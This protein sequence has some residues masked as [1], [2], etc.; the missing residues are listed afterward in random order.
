[1]L[2]CVITIK[3][4]GVSKS[5]C[6][7]NDKTGP[8]HSMIKDLTVYY[9]AVYRHCRT[10]RKCDPNE[11]LKRFLENRDKPTSNRTGTNTTSL[12]VNLVEK[13]IKNVPGTDAGWLAKYVARCDNTASIEKHRRLLTHDQLVKAARGTRYNGWVNFADEFTDNEFLQSAM[14]CI[15]ALSENLTWASHDFVI[16]QVESIANKPQVSPG[17]RHVFKNLVGLMVNGGKPD[18]TELR[19]M[20][21]I[22]EAMLA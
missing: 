10:C 8:I 22:A 7:K 19:K 13:F 11:V 2:D 3:G 20:L 6:L 9:D 12:L 21:I 18:L 17:R 1:M 16:S 14:D 4:Q 15:N 5:G